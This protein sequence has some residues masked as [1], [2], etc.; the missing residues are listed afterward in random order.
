M[1]ILLVDVQYEYGMKHRGINQIGEMGFH[2]VFRRL[3]HTVECFYYDDFLNDKKNLQDELLKFATG[4]NP[5][6]IYFQLAEDQFEFSTLDTLRAKYR[7]I[8]WFGDD[9]WRFDTFTKV[10]APHFTYNV[11]TDPFAVPKYNEI[12]IKNVFL[13]Q[14]AS[15]DYEFPM[16]ESYVDY[17]YDVS[18]IGGSNSVR[19]WFVKELEKRDIKVAAFGF[20]WPNGTVKLNEMA[21]IFRTSK[22]NLNLSN[23][24]C[25]D[26]RYLVNNIKNP[27]VAL[28]SP[29]NASQIKARNFEIPYFGGFQLTN[30]VPTIENYLR[31]GEEIICYSDVDEAAL[32]I[33]HFLK[34]DAKRETIRKQG[35]ERARKEHTFFQRH[36]TIFEKIK[37]LS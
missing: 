5:D 24:N 27:I 29:K 33:K 8:N 3:G 11:T 7:T 12:G 26:I 23:S 28:R 4:L 17:K 37:S 9:Q 36:K 34:D 20:G 32:Q 18:F 21:K 14:W 1:K 13:S 15:I 22:I 35:M 16:D 25:Y 6:L 31:I 30:Y 10:Y 2:Q 19:R